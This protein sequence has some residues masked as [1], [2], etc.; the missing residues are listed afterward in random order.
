MPG[1]PARVKI[2][3]NAAAKVL[4]FLALMALLSGLA[5]FAYL[6]FQSGDVYPPYSTLRTD[7]IGAKAIFQSV[8][9]LQPTKVRR[10]VQP[11]TLMERDPGTTIV[12]LGVEAFGWNEQEDWLKEFASEGGRVVLALDARGSLKRKVFPRAMPPGA[13][14]TN[15]NIVVK[16]WAP[17]FD[18]E[19]RSPGV[20]D[21]TNRIEAIRVADEPRLPESMPWFGRFA[22]VTNDWQTVYEI[23]NRPVVVQKKFGLGTIVV[24]ADS[25][26]YSNEAL[27]AA[28]TPEFLL[29]TLGT[30]P[31][32]FD[33]THLGIQGGSGVAVLMREFRLH[34]LVAG[35][36]LL[37]ILWIWRNS[38]PLVPPPPLAA[39]SGEQAMEGK[40]AREAVVHLLRRN[41]SGGEALRVG[42]E[43]WA[44]ANPPHYYWETV[45][46]KEAEEVAKH[47]ANVRQPNA[48]AAAHRQLSELLFPKKH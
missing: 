43:E 24:I 9:R 20:T 7:P 12:L 16:T 14:G 19:L 8:N 40:T 41:L 3:K 44:K 31:V 27:R 18:L 6:R 13:G 32:V 34:G 33:E 46:L 21:D 26:P 17:M 30:G 23:N 15:T 37:A 39:E 5:R 35:C 2:V 4:L 45:R 10:N 29:W 42:L 22:F 48:L 28:R 1:A 47:A 25:Y 36:L 11:L 38:A